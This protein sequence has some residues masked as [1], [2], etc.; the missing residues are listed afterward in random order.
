MVET[1]YRWYGKKIVWG[2]CLLIFVL[3][4]YLFFYTTTPDVTPETAVNQMP[5]VTVASAANTSGDSTFNAVGTLQAVSEAKLQTESGGRI[6]G[7]YTEL[8]ATVRAGSIIARL[9]GASESAQ[10]LQAQGA[11]EAAIAGSA[12]GN[13]GV[14]EAE[15]A[16]RSSQD[17]A[18]STYKNAYTTVSGIVFTTIDQFFS[19]PN[20]SLPGVRLGSGYT[21]FLNTERIALQ[22]SL[23]A[24][25][26]K[27]VSLSSSGNLN[28]A[29]DE[30]AVT[31]KKIVAIV[32][33]YID[34]LN[35]EDPGT[36]YSEA[37]LRDLVVTFTVA[38]NQLIGVLTSIDAA[39]A[40]LIAADESLK[41][42]KISGSGATVSSADAQ[43]KI[44]LGS[45]RAAQASY[46]K[47]IVRSP[48]SGVVNALYLKTGE[49]ASP[50]TPA[51]I[52]ANNTQGL[53]VSTSVSQEESALLKIGDEVRIEKIATGTIGAIGGSID[54]TTGKVAL[55]ISVEKN[56][57]LENGST[58]SVT[59]T[60]KMSV[61]QTEI[62][63]PLSAV[64]MTGSG[65]IVF[66]VD[67]QKKILVAN[68]VTLGNIRGEVVVV[69][70]GIGRDTEIVLDG[71][72]LKEGTEVTVKTK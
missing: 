65:P 17:G 19:D 38:R 18:L 62:T 25:Q 10:L 15:N 30:A 9:E 16:V 2:V 44:A 67:P 27:T 60:T 42:A 14:N 4:T 29:L 32:D 23:P 61:D 49:Y 8:G 54:P 28:Q 66:T 26:A 6:V 64:K 39:K 1:L 31:T 72:G 52:I 21:Q 70:T 33:A 43:I 56:S 11:Y 48:I 50:A 34:T 41:R 53:E 3:A 37:D 24:W 68:P 13:V 20:S 45:L 51:A 63:I 58:V 36:K 46:E 12:Q 59:F 69:S 47:T 35:K 7:V 40:S 22:K 57:A 5:A 55:K 71:R